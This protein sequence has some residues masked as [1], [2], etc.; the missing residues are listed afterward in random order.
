MN[1]EL[2]LLQFTDDQL[3]K[4]EPGRPLYIQLP[5]SYTA[6]AMYPDEWINYTPSGWFSIGVSHHEGYE[7][8]ALD[9][10]A[11]NSFFLSDIETGKRYP[12]AIH[13]TVRKSMHLA[14]EKKLGKD[15]DPEKGLEGPVP[16]SYLKWIEEEVVVPSLGKVARADAPQTYGSTVPKD[17][18]GGKY[19]A[20]NASA[21]CVNIQEHMI[22]A[23]NK[24]K[25][26]FVCVLPAG[27]KEIAAM[28][29]S[30]M[31]QLGAEEDCR[32]ISTFIEDLFNVGTK[33]S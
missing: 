23:I 14:I 19:T 7:T 22:T 8:D 9:A 2:R 28:P 17:Q 26:E 16:D 29:Y 31:L 33:I 27:G 5:V 15:Y 32:P 6:M 21:G 18:S 10:A 12:A 4:Y 20:I 30:L 1:P 24:Y 3:A 25:P 11:N 13:G